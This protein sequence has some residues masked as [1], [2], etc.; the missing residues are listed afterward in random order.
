MRRKLPRWKR[1][2][3]AAVVLSVLALLSSYILYDIVLTIRISA[4]AWVP[5]AAG[6]CRGIGLGPNE[7]ITPGGL[8]RFGTVLPERLHVVNTG[9]VACQISNLSLSIG[10]EWPVLSQ[11][12]PIVAGPGASAL[13]TLNFEVPTQGADERAVVTYEVTPVGT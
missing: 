8:F 12:T 2:F 4:V 9:A 1:I 7:V 11:N 6:A 3:R 10:G 13:L 5:K